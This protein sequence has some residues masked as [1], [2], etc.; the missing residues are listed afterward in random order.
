MMNVAVESGVKRSFREYEF[1]AFGIIV[2][3]AKSLL[4]VRLPYREVHVNAFYTGL[5]LDFQR[6]RSPQDSANDLQ[7]DLQA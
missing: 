6:L 3:I 4:L 5:L 7:W 1:I 2:F